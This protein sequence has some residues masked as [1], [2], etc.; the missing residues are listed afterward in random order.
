MPPEKICFLSQDAVQLKRLLC[1]SSWSEG[2]CRGRGNIYEDAVVDVTFVIEFHI[3]TFKTEAL[4]IEET[5]LE[6]FITETGV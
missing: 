4:E 2:R 3:E 6:V 5:V 1:L